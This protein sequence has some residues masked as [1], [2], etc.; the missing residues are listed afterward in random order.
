MYSPY[1]K[2]G[3]TRAQNKYM[4]GAESGE[5]DTKGL[6]PMRPPLTALSAQEDRLSDIYGE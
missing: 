4:A 1:E 3:A 2:E 6:M 5:K